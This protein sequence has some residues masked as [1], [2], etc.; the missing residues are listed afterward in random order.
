MFNVLCYSQME[1]QL[2]QAG[3]P[4][5]TFIDKQ[6][7]NPCKISCLNDF[8]HGRACVH[9]IKFCFTC[10]EN[11]SVNQSPICPW[12]NYTTPGDISTSIP[13]S[14]VSLTSSCPYNRFDTACDAECTY[15]YTKKMAD[16]CRHSMVRC[17]NCGNCWDGFAQCD[18]Q[19]YRLEVDDTT[20]YEMSS[21]EDVFQPRL[22]LNIPSRDTTMPVNNEPDSTTDL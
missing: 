1:Q 3:V 9:N 7:T 10:S 14:F 19:L 16:I 2:E 12:H 11:Y 5:A 21:D 20:D 13:D 15:I 18:C 6:T 4:L 22:N 8:T 17:H